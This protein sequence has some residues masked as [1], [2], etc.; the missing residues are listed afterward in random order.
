[1]P[2]TYDNHTT[3]TPSH[4]Q[5]LFSDVITRGKE[6]KRGEK[7]TANNAVEVRLAFLLSLSLHLWRLFF[8]SAFLLTFK[9]NSKICFGLWRGG[10]HGQ[11]EDC[12][13]VEAY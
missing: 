1:L 11:A 12:A 2:S 5:P 3:H 10:A 6:Q 4:A 13:V 9:K 8:S 7:H